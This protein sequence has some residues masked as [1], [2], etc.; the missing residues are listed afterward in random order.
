MDRRLEEEV[1]APDPERTCL[2]T[3]TMSR[4]PQAQSIADMPI[5][6]TAGSNCSLSDH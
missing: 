1:R 2:Q 4:V 5:T 3:D 6:D